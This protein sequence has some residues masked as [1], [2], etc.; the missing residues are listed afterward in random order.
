VAHEW[1]EMPL[2]T[3]WSGGDEDAVE[4]LREL[5]AEVRWLR[6]IEAQVRDDLG[7]VEAALGAPWTEMRHLLGE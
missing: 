7:R 4:E 2:A 3:G 1:D 6:R 5:A